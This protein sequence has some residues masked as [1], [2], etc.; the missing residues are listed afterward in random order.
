M[1]ALD[2]SVRPAMPADMPILHWALAWAIMWRAP[3]PIP[4]PSVVIADTG[5][6]YLLADW[7]RPVDAGVDE[8][9]AVVRRQ[10]WRCGRLIGCAVRPTLREARSSRLCFCSISSRLA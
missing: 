3:D 1:R 10:E 8:V 5:H 7:G 2:V 6:A 4:D 9:S